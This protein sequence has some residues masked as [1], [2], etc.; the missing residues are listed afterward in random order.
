MFFQR[1]LFGRHLEDNEK[2]LYVGHKHWREI[3]L[4]L[5]KIS[6]FGLVF[7]WGIYLL[8]GLIGLFWF[9]LL[10]TVIVY[11]RIIFIL[12][13][14]YF[15]AVIVT[16]ESLLFIEWHGIFNQESTRV[17]YGSVE[18]ISIETKGFW[19]V[20]LGYA[21]ISIERD[22]APAITI[23]KIRNPKR[24]E[25]EIMKGKE[26]YEEKHMS[27]NSEALH[28][29]LSNLVANHIKKNGWKK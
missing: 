19:D 10:A 14:W 9:A 26:T 29:I 8:T 21:T 11:I 18:S 15:D 24:L 4:S 16:S 27:Q 17:T 3:V 25:L 28:D 2:I 20:V 6:F 13:D 22:A 12:I 7:P 5:F 1:I 23:E